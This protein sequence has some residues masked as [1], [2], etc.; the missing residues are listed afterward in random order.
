MNVNAKSVLNTVN[1]WILTLKRPI[2]LS[3]SL[4]LIFEQ[5]PCEQNA[6]MW[7]M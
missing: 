3:L 7:N 6:A 4:A 2:S 1:A 5:E